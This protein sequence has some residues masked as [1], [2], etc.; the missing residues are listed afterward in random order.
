MGS[1]QVRITSGRFIRTWL[2]AF[3]IHRRPF[4]VLPVPA[5]GRPDDLVH[6]LVGHCQIYKGV[7]SLAYLLDLLLSILCDQCGIR[8]Q[9]KIL[10]RHAIDLVDIDAAALAVG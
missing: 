1:N 3:G 6:S 2:C 10:H 4:P 8:Q 9:T 5:T 7:G